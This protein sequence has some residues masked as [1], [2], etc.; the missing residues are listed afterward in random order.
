MHALHGSRFWETA[1]HVR[2]TRNNVADGTGVPGSR[3]QSPHPWQQYALRVLF[4]VRQLRRNPITRIECE[5]G[6]VATGRKT[7]AACGVPGGA[8]RLQFDITRLIQPTRCH[9]LNPSKRAGCAAKPPSFA[10]SSRSPVAVFGSA[11]IS[12]PRFPAISPQAKRPE[13]IDSGDFV[14][15]PQ[16]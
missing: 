6:T 9:P 13:R 11:G 1:R 7:P 16:R 5:T 12:T 10:V 2:V 15:K 14:N 8:T 3:E 4:H